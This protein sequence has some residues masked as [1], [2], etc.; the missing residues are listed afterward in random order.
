MTKMINNKHKIIEK[1]IKQLEQQKAQLVHER[2]QEIANIIIKYG[3]IGLDD[4]LL[5]GFTIFATD[6]A[7]KNSEFLNQI[8]GL[9]KETKIPRSKNK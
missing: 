9:A 8:L 2:S 1:R 3:G 7:N 6:E 5:A 4:R